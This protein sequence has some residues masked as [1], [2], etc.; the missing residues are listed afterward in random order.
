MATEEGPRSFAVFIQEISNGEIEAEAS[1]E[2]QKLLAAL[3]DDAGQRG[4][5]V[6]GSLTLTIKYEVDNKG[7][8]AVSHAVEKKL[9][10]KLRGGG[11]CWITKGSNYSL[12]PPKKKTGIR[13]VSNSERIEE[14]A[15]QAVRSV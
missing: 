8:C 10:K 12:D 11:V 7:N 13:N 15:K 1:I 9:P 2:Q 4:S 14:P 3:E 6:S 5:K